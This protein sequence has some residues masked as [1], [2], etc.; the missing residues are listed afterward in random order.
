MPYTVVLFGSP[1]ESYPEMACPMNALGPFEE[2]EEA[3]AVADEYLEHA[4]WTKPH[5]LTL[6]R[7]L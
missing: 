7:E 4:A 3:E 1:C 6:D 5:I 2:R